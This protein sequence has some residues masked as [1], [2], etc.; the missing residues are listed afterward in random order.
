MIL[1]LVCEKGVKSHVDRKLE[2]DKWI[3]IHVL[4]FRWHVFCWTSAINVKLGLIKSGH[5]ISVIVWP[6]KVYFCHVLYLRTESTDINVIATNF[7]FFGCAGISTNGSGLFMFHIFPSSLNGS[8][9][10]ST[11]H[12]VSHLLKTIL[13]VFQCLSVSINS[14]DTKNKIASLLNKM[15]NDYLTLKVCHLNCLLDI[16]IS[17]ELANKER[18]KIFTPP[19]NLIVNT[20]LLYN[21]TSF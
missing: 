20:T 7:E 15:P 1:W 5:I 3:C 11:S 4:K 6:N 8:L 16:Y 21:N 13:N 10:L 14:F 9:C 12:T 19:K 18:I 17:E 2:L